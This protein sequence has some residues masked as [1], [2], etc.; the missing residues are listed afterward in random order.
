ME[1][2]ERIESVIDR[3]FNGA[4]AEYRE[5]VMAAMQAGKKLPLFRKVD[6][7]GHIER[8]RGIREQAEG[9]LEEAGSVEVPETD[10]MYGEL[11]HLLKVSLEDFVELLKRNEAHYDL[12]DRKQYRQNKVTVEDFRLSLAGVQT[13]TGTAVESLDLLD[14]TWRYSHGEDVDMGERDEES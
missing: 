1:Y 4:L 14:R 13:G 12:M 6:F 5:A 8:F 10:E 3:Y 9:L 7:S 2:Q 11:K